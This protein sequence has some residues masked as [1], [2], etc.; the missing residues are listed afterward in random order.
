MWYLRFDISKKD[1]AENSIHIFVYTWSLIES[2]IACVWQIFHALCHSRRNMESYR[3]LRLYISHLLR[4]RDRKQNIYMDKTQ[5][6]RISLVIDKIGGSRWTTDKVSNNVLNISSNYL[7]IFCPIP[8]K[9]VISC[10]ETCLG[11]WLVKYT[12]AITIYVSH[13]WGN[14]WHIND[15]NVAKFVLYH[16]MML[17]KFANL[18]QSDRSNWVMWQ[19]KD[20]C[21]RPGWDGCLT[22]EKM[23]F[24]KSVKTW[25]ILLYIWLNL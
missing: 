5:G 11:V 10:Y 18:S 23:A 16:L 4:G 22:R 1:V 6:S 21:P 9:W 2:V 24:I 12:D 14:S 17:M 19:V 15:W 20:P 7:N 13:I 3:Y 25:I 8:N